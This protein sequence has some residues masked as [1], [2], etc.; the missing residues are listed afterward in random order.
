V[1][2]KEVTVPPPPS[3][4]DS[5]IHCIKE[6]NPAA[7]AKSIIEK[8]TARLLCEDEDYINFFNSPCCHEFTAELQAVS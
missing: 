8:R 5:N 6:G 2:R 3:C 1:G 4:E 7:R